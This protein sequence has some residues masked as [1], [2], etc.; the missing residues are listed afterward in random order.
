MVDLKSERPIPEDIWEQ[1]ALLFEGHS[2]EDLLRQILLSEL[3]KLDTGG[4]ADLNQTD[5]AGR[6]RDRED[7]GQRGSWAGRAPRSHRDKPFAKKR[8]P[9]SGGKAL[10]KPSWDDPKP[11]KPMGAGKAKRK[12]KKKPPFKPGQEPW[13]Q[14]SFGGPGFSVK[15]KKKRK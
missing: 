15:K 6:R 12:A 3:R 2:K 10:P 13:N 5:M 4:K 9:K 7:R 14:T 1:M 8:K 11:G